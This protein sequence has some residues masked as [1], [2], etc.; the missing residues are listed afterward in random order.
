VCICT[1]I[2]CEDI[3]KCGIYFG[4]WS[5]FH[6]MACIK[7]QSYQGFSPQIDS[8]LKIVTKKYKTL[9]WF[10]GK[11]CWSWS[12]ICVCQRVD[13]NMLRTVRIIES[14]QKAIRRATV[15]TSVILQKLSDHM[16]VWHTFEQFRVQ[17][18]KTDVTTVAIAIRGGE[19]VHFLTV[20]PALMNAIVF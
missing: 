8:I 17:R 10:G 15:N 7:W 12:W 14:T 4:A 6:F 11:N 20:L 2:F 9:Y 5:N 1:N 13:E 3:L 18:G 19:H 16:M